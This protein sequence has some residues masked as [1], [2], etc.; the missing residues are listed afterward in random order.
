[1]AKMSTMPRPTYAP[2][3]AERTRYWRGPWRRRLAFARAAAA[4]P[5]MVSC[6]TWSSRRSSRRRGRTRL[7]ANQDA[8]ALDPDLEGGNAHPRIVEALSRAQIET[9]LVDGRGDL[10]DAAAVPDDPPRQDKRLAEGIEIA[11]RVDGVGRGGAHQRH[12]PARH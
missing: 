7:A 6:S 8:P 1:M 12:L 5:A 11:D 10:R 9:L 2:A 4:I 3:S